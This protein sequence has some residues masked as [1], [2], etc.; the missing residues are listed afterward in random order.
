MW[1]KF[2]L[3]ESSLIA[4]VV[5]YYR[6]YTDWFYPDDA[7]VESESAY[8]NCVKKNTNV[9]ISVSQNDTEVGVCGVV[10]LS[11]SL[12]REDQVYRVVCNN[13]RG[14]YGNIVY[15]RKQF[16]IDGKIAVYEFTVHTAGKF[17]LMPLIYIIYY[18]LYSVYSIVYNVYY[19][20]RII[21]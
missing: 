1:L 16:D 5:Y 12:T 20:L 6:F 14:Y 7:C 10:T 15:L 3:A 17:L 9:S 2:E 19:T 13:G 4:Y 8:R 18:T 11:Q 21:K